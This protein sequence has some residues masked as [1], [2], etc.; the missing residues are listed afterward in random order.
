[1]DV[2]KSGTRS[3]P[4]SRLMSEAA[5][6]WCKRPRVS[7]RE[8]R[9][10]ISWKANPNLCCLSCGSTYI[11]LRRVPLLTAASTPWKSATQLEVKSDWRERKIAFPVKC[12]VCS[13]FRG[14]LFN[15]GDKSD[16]EGSHKGISFLKKRREIPYFQ[17][18]NSRAK[19]I[20]VEVRCK[21]AWWVLF[22]CMQSRL[23]VNIKCQTHLQPTVI[24]CSLQF[25][26]WLVIVLGE[27]NEDSICMSSALLGCF[28]TELFTRSTTNAVIE[29]V[30]VF[31][32]PAKL[33]E[34]LWK[35]F[36]VISESF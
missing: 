2:D 35:L 14:K 4:G 12:K 31:N 32:Q 19:L 20:W 17:S 3:Q 22:G 13:C 15:E 8:R 16:F 34:I 33:E 10:P 27:S 5:W 21:N 26:N 24:I 28:C 30:R 7:F 9:A 18:H 11:G 6:Y 36:S 25:L 29:L 23:Q 1:M